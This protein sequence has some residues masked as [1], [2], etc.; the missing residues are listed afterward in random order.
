MGVFGGGGGCGCVC[1]CVC[2]WDLNSHLRFA[3]MHIMAIFNPGVFL[4]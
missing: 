1:V 3:D 4:H 2:V